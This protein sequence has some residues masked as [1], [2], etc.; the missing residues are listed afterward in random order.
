MFR[1]NSPFVII[2]Y[3]FWYNI[4]DII[5]LQIGYQKIIKILL[6]KLTSIQYVKCKYT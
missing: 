2:K 6:L 1:K 5:Q 3:K 4:L